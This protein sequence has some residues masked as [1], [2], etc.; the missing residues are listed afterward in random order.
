[1][2]Q[3]DAS[4]DK[5]ARRGGNSRGRSNGIDKGSPK[6]RANSGRIH[7]D[8]DSFLENCARGVT[9]P[10]KMAA[11]YSIVCFVAVLYWLEGWT[12]IL[13]ALSTLA[14]NLALLI[15]GVRHRRRKKKG[16]NWPRL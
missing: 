14:A 13:T 2:I 6:T 9:D 16:N 5:M 15:R 7:R 3:D 10:L 11:I 4:F 1:M 8:R 12:E